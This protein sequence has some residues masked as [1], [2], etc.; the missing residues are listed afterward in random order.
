[1][2]TDLGLTRLFPTPVQIADLGD[3][4]LPGPRTRRETLLTVCRDLADGTLTLGVGDDATEQ[5]E[6]LQGYRG[7]GPWTTGYL[8]MRVLGNPDV[9]LTG[10]LAIRR[11]ARASGFAADV[12]ALATRAAALMPWRSYLSMH[13]WA[14][15]GPAGRP[16]RAEESS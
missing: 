13:L 11:G 12:P 5:A 14:A 1:V 10:D 3:D 4:A 6:R 2:D 8:A 9:L 16:H 15:A 7:I